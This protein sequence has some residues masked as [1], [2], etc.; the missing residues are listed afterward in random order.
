MPGARFC[1]PLLPKAYRL[2]AHVQAQLRQALL[3]ACPL[4]LPNRPPLSSVLLLRPSCPDKIASTLQTQLVVFS[5]DRLR[6]F[7]SPLLIPHD[8]PSA[9]ATPR[10]SLLCFSNEP[11]PSY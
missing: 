9:P 1:N 7:Y 3:D 8:F 4:H 11:L 5:P 10:S 2:R 6:K